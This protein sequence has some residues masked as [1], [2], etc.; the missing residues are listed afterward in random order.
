VQYAVRVWD[1]SLP[2][3]DKEGVVEA[4]IGRLEDFYRSLGLPVRLSEAGI[5]GEK[6]REMAEKTMLGGWTY[7]GNFMELGIDD[8]EKI[9][10]LAL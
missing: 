9:L 7:Q 6:L 3:N 5:G 2:L 10:K 1:V 8:I 4:A